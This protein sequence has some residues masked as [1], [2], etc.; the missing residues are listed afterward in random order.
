MALLGAALLPACS[1]TRSSSYRTTPGTAA[2][3]EGT[4]RVTIT[5]APP[6]AVQVG[7]VEVDS[8]DELARAVEELQR[9]T[10]EM[11]G[12][13]AVIDRYSTSFEMRQH[14]STQSYQCGQSTCTRQVVQNYEASILH[15]Y[16]RALSTRGG[17]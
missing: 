12:D 8:E 5:A 17:P 15:L 11:G 1:G 14:T 2:P 10:A 13:T 6:G 4:V 3:Y 7:L 16:G 9:R